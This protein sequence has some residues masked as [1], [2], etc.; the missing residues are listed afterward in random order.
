MINYS[1]PE[2]HKV[3]PVTVRLDGKVVGTIQQ[4][5]GGFQ[6]VPKGKKDGGEVFG[7]VAAVKRL[8]EAED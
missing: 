7:S 8:L 4:V 3:A 5:E 2:P 1:Y 6:Y